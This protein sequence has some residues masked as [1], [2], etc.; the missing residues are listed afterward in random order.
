MKKQKLW[1]RLAPAAALALLCPAA[2]ADKILHGVPKV[3]FG[4]DGAT[5]F[6]L[7]A[8]AC[9]EFLGG[10]TPYLFVMAGSGSAFRLT[11]DT[12]CWNRGNVWDWRSYDDDPD[13]VYRLGFASIGRAVKILRRGEA[14]TRDEFFDFAKAQVDLGNPCVALGVLGP[15]EACIVAGYYDEG[16]AFVGW[17]LF[18]EWVQVETDHNGYYITRGWWD[19]KDTQ[20]IMSFAEKGVE[21]PSFLEIVSNAVEVLS[22]REDGDFAKGLMAYDAWEKAVL[23][24]AEF[25]AGASFD[26]MFDRQMSH[27]D[28]MHCL[29]DGRLNAAAFF[30]DAATRQPRHAALCEAIAKDFEAV[31]VPVMKMAE[32]LG[33]WAGAGVRH[34]LLADPDVRRKVAAL[35]AEAKESDEKAF[36]KMKDLLTALTETP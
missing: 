31:R 6:P 20:A 22:P 24:D 35:I 21:P 10:E 8:R 19:T 16:Q 32:H 23:D 34:T 1:K 12:T 17:N 14:T 18:Q 25:P 5:P 9:D 11:W 27:D 4:P 7:C 30:K 33:G 15:P 2:R 26:A 3:A 36:E 29:M 28:A 13:R